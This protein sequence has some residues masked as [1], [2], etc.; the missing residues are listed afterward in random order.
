[1]DDIQEKGEELIF[2]PFSYW[3]AAGALHQQ[4]SG[5]AVQLQAFLQHAG[6]GKLLRG[7]SESPRSPTAYPTWEMSI[8]PAFRPC[9]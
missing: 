5:A 9:S 1:M 4:L 7:G 3:H 2:T 6:D 8:L